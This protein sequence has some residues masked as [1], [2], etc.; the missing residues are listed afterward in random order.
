MF[1]SAGRTGREPA[2]HFLHITAAPGRHCRVCARLF[3][4]HVPG[5][6][7]SAPTEL[8]MKP[9]FRCTGRE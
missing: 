2:H 9:S 4:G 6:H 8:A 3:E 5:I 1:V 7:F